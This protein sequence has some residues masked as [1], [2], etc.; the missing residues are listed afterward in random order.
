MRIAFVLGSVHISGGNYV[1]VQHAMHAAA[2]GHDVS[3]V[4]LYRF[5]PQDLAWHS[6]LAQ[7]KLIHIDDIGGQRFDLA[8][9][10][11]W[12][13]VLELYRLDARQYAYFVQSIESRFFDASDV[14]LRRLVDSTYELRLPGVTEAQWIQQYLAET[15]G[16]RYLLARNGIRKDLYTIDGPCHVPRTRGTLRVVVEGPMGV[17]IKNTART[18]RIVRRASVGEAWLLTSTSLAWHPGVRRLFSRIPIYEV[19]KV[20]RSCDVIVKLSLVEGMFG[21]PLEMFHC[22]GTAIVYAVSGHDEYIRHG[23]NALVANMHDEAAVLRHLKQLRDDPSLLDRLKA[24]AR[25]TADAWP[26]WPESS[27]VFTAQLEALC[28]GELISREWLSIETAR[29]RSEFV[30]ELPQSVPSI[31]GLQGRSGLSVSISRLKDCVRPFSSL[32]GYIA[33]GYR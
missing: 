25:E 31:D 20:Y 33:D 9:A 5:Q 4:I 28:D 18:L 32:L 22:G 17:P 30:K 13:T 12:K 10:T 7:L 8:V 3:L 21:P 2:C 1:V 23:H 27:A 24:G 11:W 14:S 6:G 19:A 16:S 15:Y 29:I 26:G